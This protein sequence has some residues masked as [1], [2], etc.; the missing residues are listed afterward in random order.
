MREGNSPKPER[1]LPVVAPMLLSKLKFR[2]ND[3]E[4]SDPASGRHD[5]NDQTASPT[6]LICPNEMGGARNLDTAADP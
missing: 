3:A 5:S 6:H 1:A 2:T 4:Q